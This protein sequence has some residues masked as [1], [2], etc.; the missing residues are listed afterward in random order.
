MYSNFQKSDHDSE[1]ITSQ[2]VP[3]TFDQDCSL[4]ES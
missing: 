3:R 2:G 4:D 1:Y